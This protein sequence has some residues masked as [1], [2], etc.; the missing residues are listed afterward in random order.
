MG[1]DPNM[2]NQI[3]ETLKTDQIS[4]QSHENVYSARETSMDL[5]SSAGKRI[6]QDCTV[7]WSLIWLVE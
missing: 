1:L 3:Q 6:D 5:V 4:V 2:P 7:G